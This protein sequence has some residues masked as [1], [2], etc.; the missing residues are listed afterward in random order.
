M[1]RFKLIILLVI[2]VGLIFSCGTSYNIQNSSQE[3]ALFLVQQSEAYARTVF[4]MNV[5]I[6][7][8]NF[9]GVFW[10]VA[11]QPSF[12]DSVKAPF[13]HFMLTQKVDGSYWVVL[14]NDE[15]PP[16]ITVEFEVDISEDF[17][18]KEG[19]YN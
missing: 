2:I 1:K 11:Y 10:P 14:L 15:R 13:S 9:E 4:Y 12:A 5:K 19:V 18:Y 16:K 7:A 8:S 3:E 6:G 17:R